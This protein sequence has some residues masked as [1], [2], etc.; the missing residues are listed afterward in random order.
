MSAVSFTS[1]LL[2]SAACVRK[3]DQTPITDPNLEDTEIRAVD[4]SNYPEIDASGTAYFDA[5]GNEAGLFQIMSANGVNTV[6]LRLWVAPETEHSGFF[7]VRRLSRELKNLGFKT[8]LSLHYSDTWAD[9][10]AQ[11]TPERWKGLSFE[12]LK[13]SVYGYTERVASQLKPDFLQLGNEVNTGILHPQG[14]IADEPEQFLELLQTAAGAVKKASPNTQTMVHFAGIEGAA[15]FF[16]QLTELEYDIIGLS[17]YPMWH[18]KSLDR[19]SGTID[20]LGSKYQKQVLVAETAYP[21]TLQWADWTNNIVGETSQLI[22][23]YE[24]TVQGQKAYL[25][26]VRNLV[27]E[28]RY[29]AG[30]CYWGA[31][32]VAWKGEKGENASPWENQALFDFNNHAVPAL[33][34]F[35]GK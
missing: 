12:E 1:L 24:A 27:N 33:E 4:I 29:G 16:D 9:P 3:I 34:V 11:E 28:S 31:E 23:E 26:A 30:F 13:D 14:A 20:Q 25:E 17:Y 19:L 6:R 10:G 15:W 21:F 2:F 5:T 22:P 7:E 18:G 32:L 35:G 8:W